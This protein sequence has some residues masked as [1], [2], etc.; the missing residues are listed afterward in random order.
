MNRPGESAMSERRQGSWQARLHEVIFEA[1]TPAGRMFDIALLSAILLSVL[2]VLLESIDS[3]SAR[4]G[5]ELRLTEWL[6]TALFTVEYALRLLSV[7]QPLRYATGFFGLVDLLAILPTYLSLLVPGT[8]SLMAVRTLR[9]LRIFR[10]FK[11]TRYV[12]EA[13][14]VIA[15]LRASRAKILVFLWAV[16]TIVVIVGALMYVIEGAEHGFTSIP[17]SIYWAIVTMTTVGYGDMAPKTAAGQLL[18]SALMIVGYAII[19]IPTGIVSVEL[20]SAHRAVSTQACPVCGSGGHDPDARHC[21]RC[22]AAL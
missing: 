18:A 21:K 20:A 16:L 22:G 5:A 10:V 14:V 9:L 4:Y 15:A 2:A 12:G 13:N 11:L 17:Q 7:R 6:F 19:A 3:V 1:D 8:H